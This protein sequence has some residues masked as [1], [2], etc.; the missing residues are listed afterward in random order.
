MARP[1]AAAYHL[2]RQTYLTVCLTCTVIF[3]VAA[4]IASRHTLAG[5][6][7]AIFSMINGWP[8]SLRLVF[9]G[10]TQL[11]NAWMLLIAPL[12][13]YVAKQRVL[14]KHLLVNGLITVLLVEFTKEI[15]NRPRPGFLRTGVS[16]REL[17]VNGSSFPSGHTAVASVLA[18][19]LLPYI[20]RRYWWLLGLWILS[21]AVSRMYLGVHAP[22]DIIG[23]ITLAAAV[24]AASHLWDTTKTK[25]NS[26]KL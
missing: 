4:A 21:V 7:D 18:L 1:A 12:V 23:G 20:P 16:V 14:A 22:L 5:W 25:S 15:V 10:V 19:T 13:A 2:T 8:D 3:A 17:F 11:G 26:N 24:V 6:E 9:L